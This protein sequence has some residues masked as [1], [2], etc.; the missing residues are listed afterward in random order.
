MDGEPGADYHSGLQAPGRRLSIGLSLTLKV[1]PVTSGSAAQRAVGFA[2][3]SQARA[4][5][6]QPLLK[7]YL[8]GGLEGVRLILVGCRCLGFVHGGDPFD[9]HVRGTA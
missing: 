1:L 4:L 6:R 5:R 9:P 8:G 2:R 7:R 3:R